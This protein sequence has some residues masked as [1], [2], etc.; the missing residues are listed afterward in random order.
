MSKFLQLFNW[1]LITI[2]LVA[3]W[4]FFHGVQTLAFLKDPSFGSPQ[5]NAFIEA[6]QK[7]RYAID[8]TFIEQMGNIGLLFA[9]VLAWYIAW[10]RGWH[11][12]NDVL[13]FVIAFG[14]GY[15]NW[16]GWN[17]F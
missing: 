11:W 1:R 10:K 13:A 9:Y 4:F 15:F 16:G 6:G 8:K 3:F 5:L 2:H 12:L 7:P 17:N 14:L